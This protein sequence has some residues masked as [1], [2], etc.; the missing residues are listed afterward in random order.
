MPDEDRAIAERI[1]AI[2]K[3]AAPD[4]AAKT[5][6]GMP[7][8]ANPAGKTICFFQP[9]SK[10][11]ARYGTLGFNDGARLDDG[12]MWPTS[13]AI[14]KLTKENEARIAALVRKAAG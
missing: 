13:F 2:V 1:H 6:Y 9:A 7:A 11:K 10:F 8:Y 12:S 14:V 4:L 5:W 3:E